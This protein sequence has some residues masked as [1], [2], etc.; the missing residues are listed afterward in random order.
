[1][2]VHKS[3][4]LVGLLEH[5]GYHINSSAEFPSTHI[6][7]SKERT[8]I[9]PI[10]GNLASLFSDLAIIGLANVI[11]ARDA[12]LQCRSPF[13]HKAAVRRTGVIQLLGASST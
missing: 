8:Y 2:L 7:R 10:F 9:F 4:L 13:L 12:L 5:T 1:M 3:F 11:S 6:H